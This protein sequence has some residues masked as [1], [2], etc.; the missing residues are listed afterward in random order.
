[1][2]VCV[3]VCVERFQENTGQI[4]MK[5]NIQILPS[6]IPTRLFNFMTDVFDDVISGLQPYFSIKLIEFWVR[7]S[8]FSANYLIALQPGSLE[9]NLLDCSLKFYNSNQNGNCNI[10]IED[11]KIALYSLSFPEYKNI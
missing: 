8:L 6:D 10:Y 7:L 2:C 11:K 5:P 9:K 3:S 1:M 4:V